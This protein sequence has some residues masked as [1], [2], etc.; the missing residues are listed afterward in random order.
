MRVA[1]DTNILIYALG[2]NDEERRRRAE[3]LIAHL[4]PG[5]I[6]LPIQVLGELM[7]VLVGKARW[8]APKARLSA[9]KYRYTHVV[10]PTNASTLEA[11]LDLAV[12]HRLS[13]WDAVILNAAAEAGCR[14]LLSEDLAEGFTWRGLTVVS[15]FAAS[16]HPL[17]A[18]L[19]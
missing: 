19:L 3:E 6:V 11:A 5:E 10:Q 4:A 13:I 7:R 17:L 12:D 15:P 9:Q 16:P 14:L 1:L 18:R 8:P 2:V